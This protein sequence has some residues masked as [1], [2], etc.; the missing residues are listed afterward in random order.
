MAVPLTALYGALHGVLNVA[1]AVNVTRVRAKTQVFLGTGESPEL[2]LAQRQHGNNAEYV[3]FALL[4][5][6]VAELQGGS[7]MMLHGLGATLTL[8]R[9]LHA[10]GVGSKPSPLRALGAVLSWAVIVTAGI[11][12]ATLSP[13]GS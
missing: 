9:V 7:A 10:V 6:L 8:G 13:R 1:L 11:Y 4:L 12:A 3:P 5:L 2:L